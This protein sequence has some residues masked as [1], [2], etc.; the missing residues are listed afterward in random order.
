MTKRNFSRFNGNANTAFTKTAY[1]YTLSNVK[2]TRRN[3]VFPYFVNA[4]ETWCLYRPSRFR[5]AET[6]WSRLVNS[7]SF[8]YCFHALFLSDKLLISQWWKN[9]WHCSKSRGRRPRCHGVSDLCR[10]RSGWARCDQNMDWSCCKSVPLHA[11]V[12]SHLSVSSA[13]QPLAASEKS[14]HRSF[15]YPF[16]YEE[17]LWTFFYKLTPSTSFPG[18][19]YPC[20]NIML[21]AYLSAHL[22]L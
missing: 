9:P 16:I 12:R 5:P 15:I 19:F 7:Y 22:Y 20:R 13:I 8:Y 10:H 3:N 14:W 4:K 6:W 21:C 18:V 17:T 1:L 11:D 2:S